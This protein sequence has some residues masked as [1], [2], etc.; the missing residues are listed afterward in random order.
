MNSLITGVDLTCSYSADF[1][2]DARLEW[3]FN[4]K[5]SQIYV[6]YNGK[7]TGKWSRSLFLFVLLHIIFISARL[8]LAVHNVL[9]QHTLTLTLH[10]T[11]VTHTTS[12]I[13][14]T[15]LSSILC[16][17]VSNVDCLLCIAQVH[18]YDLST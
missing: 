7:L 8:L 2:K 17:L 3:K 16:L 4:Q 13:I 11:C 6:F 14:Q 5:G 9:T 15:F 1:G 10:L 18:M 12:L